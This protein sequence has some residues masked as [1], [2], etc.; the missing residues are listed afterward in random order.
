M[1]LKIGDRVYIR[2]FPKEQGTVTSHSQRSTRGDRFSYR[3]VKW[4][5]LKFDGAARNDEIV[6]VLGLSDLVKFKRRVKQ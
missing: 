4:D 3:Y 5:S 1:R 2:G 6:K